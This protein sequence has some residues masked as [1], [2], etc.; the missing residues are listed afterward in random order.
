M[1]ADRI[2]CA[3]EFCLFV[4]NVRIDSLPGM[5]AFLKS[6]IP[7]NDQYSEYLSCKKWIG[8]ETLDA[9]FGKKERSRY[10]PR[11]ESV[12]QSASVGN[13]SPSVPESS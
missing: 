11:V 5:W 13:L 10:F 12:L 2:E 3:N 4:N 8:L 1:F 9:V 6:L 7:P